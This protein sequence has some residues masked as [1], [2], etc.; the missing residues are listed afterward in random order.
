MG[1]SIYISTFSTVMLDIL[2]T[3]RPHFQEGKN[4]ENLNPMAMQ[5]VMRT[6]CIFWEISN[7]NLSC[8]TDSAVAESFLSRLPPPP[9]PDQV[10]KGRHSQK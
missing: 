8:L 10:L 4:F 9:S 5:I 3:D 2:S 6:I 7:N 1:L